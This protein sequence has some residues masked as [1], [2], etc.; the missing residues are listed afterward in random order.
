ME[1]F[2]Y[3]TC[4]EGDRKISGEI[5]QSFAIFARKIVYLEYEGTT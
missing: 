2:G 3:L 4:V 1:K 5:V